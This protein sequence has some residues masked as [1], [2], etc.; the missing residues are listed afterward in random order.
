MGIVPGDEDAIVG[1]PIGLGGLLVDL[2]VEKIPYK[3]EELITIAETEYAWCEKKMKKYS[4]ELGYG[5]DWRIALEHVK[6]LYAEPGEQPE[7]IHHLADEAIDYVTKHDL[8]TVPPLAAATWRMFM[9][10]PERQKANPFFLGG[11]SILVS[12]PTNTMDHEAKMMTMRGNNIHFACSTAFHELIPVHTC[13][14]PYR[15]LFDTP[16]W[17]ERWSFYREMI[18]WDKGFPKTPENRIRMLF[19]RMHCCARIIISL[20][21]HLGEMSPRECIDLL[22]DMVGHER[23][24]AE[25]EVRRSFNGDYTPLYQAGYMLGGLQI[26]S[27]P[28]ELVQSGKVTEKEFHDRVLRENEM[29]IELLRAL[30][31]NQ[32]VTPDFKASWRFY[33]LP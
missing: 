14:R 29:L 9:M 5:N 23:S 8:V 13:N 7:L 10:S 15:T 26:Y 3:P 27:L 21:F 12:Y 19:W 16:I 24:T 1:Q 33:D 11:E 18:L 25:G 22:V 28:H 31:K 20:K 6:N 30:M 32:P 2:E 17:M 4:R